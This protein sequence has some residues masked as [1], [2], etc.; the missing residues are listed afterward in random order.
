LETIVTR[1]PFQ[2]PSPGSYS[3]K[4]LLAAKNLL[5]I[6]PP[7][8]LQTEHANS[9]IRVAGGCHGSPTRQFTAPAGRKPTV[10]LPPPCAPMHPPLSQSPLPSH[11]PI[12]Y[13]RSSASGTIVAMVGGSIMLAPPWRPNRRSLPNPFALNRLR[14]APR[15]LTNAIVLILI[16]ILLL[17]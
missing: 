13:L 3:A 4:F 7:H 17:I 10:G 8:L 16:L 5:E 6:E 1:S 11:S 9:T 2:I 15:A 14:P 12:P